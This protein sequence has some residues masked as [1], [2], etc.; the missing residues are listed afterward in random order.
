MQ[1]FARL[2]LSLGIEDP[3]ETAADR[4]F[5]RGDRVVGTEA[6]TS[7]WRFFAV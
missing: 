6:P 2:Y 4:L 1:A 5:E 7:A 3:A